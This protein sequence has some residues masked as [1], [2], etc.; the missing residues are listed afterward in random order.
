MIL[1]VGSNHDDVLYFE[2][3]MRGKTVDTLVGDIKV[4]EGTIFN[5]KVYLLSNVYSN[6]L[7]AMLTYQIIHKYHIMLVFSVGRC[8]ALTDD[9]KPGDIVVSRQTYLGEVD[10]TNVNNSLL[11]Q[12][13]H[14]PQYYSTDVYLLETM[15]ACLDHTTQASYRLGTFVSFEK[16][17]NSV[18]ILDKISKNKMMFGHDS[19]IALDSECG[20]VALACHINSVPFIAVKVAERR[21]DEKEN[22]DTYINSLRKY[23]EIGKAISSCIG[24]IGRNEVISGK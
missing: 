6:Y 19:L 20:G 5:Q 14:M 4:I 16:N 8:I 13:P 2:S 23:T 1:I 11:G 9:I 3:K 18:Q 15:Q 24:E 21:V 22:I 17:I 12:I 7:T 10:F